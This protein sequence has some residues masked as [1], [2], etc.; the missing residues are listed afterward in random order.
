MVTMK[1]P[2]APDTG[3]LERRNAERRD[4]DRLG[5]SVEVAK[6][7]DTNFYIGVTENISRGG[8]FI[9]T[10][11][12]PPVGTTIDL[13]LRLPDH[14][15]PLRVTGEVRWHRHH[16]E[17]GEAPGFGIRF[18]NLGEQAEALIRAFIEGRKPMFHPEE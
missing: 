15:Q 18:I 12:M 4:G 1:I 14:G 10:A 13:S 8:L 3:R 16:G 7:S 17:A 2:L 9:V 11:D 6:A 5:M